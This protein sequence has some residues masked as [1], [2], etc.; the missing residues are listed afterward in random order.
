MDIHSAKKNVEKLLSYIEEMSSKDTKLYS[1]SRDRLRDIAD[2]CNQVVKIISDLLQEEMLGTDSIEFRENSDIFDKALGSMEYQINKAHQFTQDV[3]AVGGIG[4]AVPS[5]V[6]NTPSISSA[7]KR[8]VFAKY[9]DCLLKLSHKPTDYHFASRCATLLWSW[10]DT[11]FYKTMPGST[12]K[13]SVR[14]F[15]EWIE[16]I[17]VLYGKAIHENSVT[18]FEAEFQEWLVSIQDTDAR[19]KYAIP[20]SVY[21]FCKLHDPTSVTLDAVVLWDILLDMG[22]H[23]LCTSDRGD[24]YM[25][26]YCIYSLCNNLN[27]LALEHYCD[28]TTH[29]EIFTTMQWEV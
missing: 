24:L 6:V 9:S 11:R 14:K 8:A 27:P 2:N 13:Y 5:N 12:F 19:D 23:K 21:Q 16:S 28:Y 3:P 1:K 17:V 22:L 29:P 20:Y 18:E 10:F 25:D 26:Q 7:T 4:S 15:P